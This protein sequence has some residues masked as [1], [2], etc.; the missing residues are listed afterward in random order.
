MPMSREM[1]LLDNKW[2][3]NQGWPKRLEWL[4]IR[5]LRGWTGQRIDF[6]FPITAIVGENGV[7]KS[8]VLQAAASIYQNDGVQRYASDFFPDTTW[9]E[10]RAAEIVGSIREGAGNSTLSSVRKPTGRWRGNP[11]RKERFTAYIDLKR[12]Q[13]LYSRTGYGRLANPQIKEAGTNNFANNALERL[14]GIMG[15]SY[16]SARMALTDAD[17][18]REIP[19]LQKDGKPFSG[20]HSG[21]GEIAITELMKET[22]YSRKNSLV[23][24]DEVETSLHPRVQRRFIRDLAAMCR[25]TESQVILTTHSPY[26]LQELPSHARI[27]LMNGAE[28]KQVVRGVSPEFAMT[29]MDEDRHPEVD[30]YVEDKRAEDLLREIVVAQ[31]RELIKRVQIVAFGAASVGLALGQMITRFPRP[32]IVFLD[33]DQP[34]APGCEILP[35]QDAPERVVFE[36][37]RERNW[38]G[39]DLRVGRNIAEVIDA[40]QAGMTSPNHHEWVHSVAS[41]LFLGSD[42]LWQ[43]MCAVWASDVL[44]D[45]E[46]K[47]ITDPIRLKLTS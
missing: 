22:F 45:Y 14:S 4:E 32:S 33:G 2:S 9:D 40:C 13:P 38:Q 15:K 37:L 8:T 42:S 23:L 18:S 46:R 25:E 41:R 24:I 10:V 27:Y 1:R 21:A 5:G 12:I 7:G 31:D 11:E 35:G 20:F 43:A 47:K 36:G 16:S 19:V 29:Q 39:I 30:V 34:S 17:T 3:S 44:P 26:V 28:G 6:D